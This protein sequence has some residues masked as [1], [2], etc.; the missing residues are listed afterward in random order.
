[1]GEQM[2]IPSGGRPR[3]RRVAARTLR[4]SIWITVTGG[5]GHR[6]V[7]TNV[8]NA[9]DLARR[10]LLEQHPTHNPHNM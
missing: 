8:T 1:L 7:K 2:D 3:S 4:Y 5:P 6:V 10:S 9:P